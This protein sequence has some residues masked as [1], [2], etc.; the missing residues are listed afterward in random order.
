[1]KKPLKYAFRITHIDN[2]PHIVQN[3]LVRK[4]SPLRNDH[5]VSIGDQ[6]IIQLRGERIVKGYRLSDFIPF[7]F[8]PRSPMLYV[9]QHGYNGVLRVEPEKIVYCVIRIEDLINN[10]I[11]CIF[12]DGHAMNEMTSFYKKD[13]L[14]QIDS[15]V[16][17][18]DVYLK[19]WHSEDDRDLKRRKEA[20]LL[21]N[22]D[23]PVSYIC[24]YVVYNKNAKNTLFKL[25]IDENKIVVR[26]DYYF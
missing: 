15:I 7:Y 2:M 13:E 3:G 9:I 11:D 25:E 23:L 5:Y 26:P 21:V 4:N 20:E 10:G 8:G 22:T 24:G 17:Y 6:Q 18:E 1:M 12:T 16:C 19:Q 14:P